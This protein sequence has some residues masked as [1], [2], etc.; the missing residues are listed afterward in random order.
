M[1]HKLFTFL[2][3][4][5]PHFTLSL[6][7]LVLMIHFLYLSLSSHSI[8]VFLSLFF[9]ISVSFFLSIYISSY[10]STR[11]LLKRNARLD[12]MMISHSIFAHTHTHTHTNTH[13]HTYTLKQTHTHTHTRKHSHTHTRAHTRTYLPISHSRLTPRATKMNRSKTKRGK[14]DLAQHFKFRIS[15]LNIFEAVND[16]KWSIFLEIHIIM[17]LENQDDKHSIF[18]IAKYLRDSLY[19]DMT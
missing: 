10:S 5:Y 1:R 16:V 3:N 8:Y 6:S 15:L 7:V 4:T 11:Q 18:K 9:L 12:E 14:I 19:I 2:I 13:T 17:K